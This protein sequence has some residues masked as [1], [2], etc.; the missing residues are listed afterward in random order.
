MVGGERQFYLFSSSFPGRLS[1]SLEGRGCSCRQTWPDPAWQGSVPPLPSLS[2]GYEH[3]MTIL[4]VFEMERSDFSAL[5]LGTALPLLMI[6]PHHLSYAR[7]SE[8]PFEPVPLLISRIM[9]ARLS[10]LSTSVPSEGLGTSYPAPSSRPGAVVKIMQR[11]F[12]LFAAA[13]LPAW[14]PSPPPCLGLGGFSMSH[15]LLFLFTGT[16]DSQ[17]HLSQTGHGCALGAEPS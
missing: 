17:G 15:V 13:L 11:L 6:N 12:C 3:V 14:L 8:H 16:S 5:I 2:Q 4:Q 10:G 1:Q 9:T 7:G